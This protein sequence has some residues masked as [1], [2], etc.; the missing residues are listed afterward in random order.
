VAV[1]TGLREG[2]IFFG[3]LMAV[4]TSPEIRLV[5][6]MMMAFIAGYAIT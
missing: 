3:D 5:F 4:P 1:Q 2:F 6:R